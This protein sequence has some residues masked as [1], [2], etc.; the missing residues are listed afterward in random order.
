M[1][2]PFSGEPHPCG[3]RAA[4]QHLI[5]SP[6]KRTRKCGIRRRIGSNGVFP[7]GV[8]QRVPRER[9]AADRLRGRRVR[10]PRRDPR[11]PGDRP[12]ARA[13]R[14]LLPARP[15]RRRQDHADPPDH[16]RAA[17]ARG[18]HPRRRARRAR[19][20]GGDQAPARRDPAVRQP[21]RRALASRTHLLRFGPLKHL[22][23]A[24]TRE[25][26]RLRAARVR[27]RAPARPARA[28]ALGRAAPQGAG[29]AGAARGSRRS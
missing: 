18:A 3:F 15:Q 6:P 7:G 19:G 5:L 8:L 20:S 24:Q 29:R 21:V 26:R 9:G 4:A 13:R 12:R 14:A 11:Q 17:P 28:H 16:D 25:R 22:S 23:R 27:A 10:L 2:S 1:L